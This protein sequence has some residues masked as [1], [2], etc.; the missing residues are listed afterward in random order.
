MIHS[1]HLLS[2]S[3]YAEL[4]KRTYDA[5]QRGEDTGASQYVAMSGISHALHCDG[6]AQDRMERFGCC[7]EESR[8]TMQEIVDCE[9][10]SGHEVEFD[11]RLLIKC[12]H[13]WTCPKGELAPLILLFRRLNQCRTK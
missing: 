3:E 13:G 7:G 2:E 10:I 9:W 12:P 4:G 5:W 6:I 8:R 11:R 1:P